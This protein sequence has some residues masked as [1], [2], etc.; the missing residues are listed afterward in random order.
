MRIFLVVPPNYKVTPDLKRALGPD[1][2]IR[3]SRD[4]SA[5]AVD[6]GLPDPSGLVVVWTDPSAVGPNGVASLVSQVSADQ[7]YSSNTAF[8]P[9]SEQVPVLAT[10][11][12]LYSFDAHAVHLSGGLD[13]TLGIYALALDLQ[14]RLTGR[15]TPGRSVGVP[16]VIGVP[17]IPFNEYLAVMTKN[18]TSQLQGIYLAPMLTGVVA[19]SLWATNTN[20]SIL[21]LQRS[22][23]NDDVNSFTYARGA[24]DGSHTVREWGAQLPSLL[25]SKA[26]TSSARRIPDKRLP[27][28]AE[29]VNEVWGSTGIA[30]PKR[31]VLEDAFAELRETNAPQLAFACASTDEAARTRLQQVVDGLSESCFWWDPVT[32]AIQ[33]WRNG[34]WYASPHS[35]RS[36]SESACVTYLIGL[37]LRSAPW[38][39][40]SSQVVVVD[41]TTAELEGSF[42]TGWVNHESGRNFQNT[43]SQQLTETVAGADRI[44]ASSQQQRDF[45]LG[46]LASELRLNQYTYDE[47]PSL[48]SLIRVENGMDA[49]LETIA[50]PIHPFERV[51]NT[52]EY[53]TSPYSEMSGGIRSHL[54]RLSAV[55]SKSIKLIKGV[56]SK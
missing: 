4:D 25:L 32:Q 41:F 44:I 15:G 55:P 8:V 13:S 29:F 7:L 36:M 2:T 49:A 6:L 54:Q 19:H 45:L 1:A 38:A 56:V 27:H 26:V 52:A 43:Q 5:S 21:D 14:L 30:D 50:N 18:L 23:G 10:A 17:S 40:T 33:E 20:T 34:Q 28:L 53:E 9:G 51:T 47:D 46:V 48:N 31:R 3:H 12:G 35:V 11:A 24:F 42:T 37:P 16:A 39:A 22:P